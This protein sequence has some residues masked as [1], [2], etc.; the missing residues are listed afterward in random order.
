ML[1]SPD[2]MRD[3]SNMSDDPFSDILKL[4]NAELVV[5][6]GLTAGGPWAIRFPAPDHIKFLALAIVKGSCWLCIDG[7]EPV[8]G[9]AGEVVLLSAQ[10]SFVLA[11]DLAAIPVD[12]TSLYAGNVSKIAKLGDR[13]DCILIGGHVQL[14]A[15]SGGLLADVLPPL[16]HVRAGSSQATVLQWL[17]DQLVRERGVELPGPVSRWRRSPSSCSSRFCVRIS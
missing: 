17:L 6:G 5:S 15:A 14:D 2:Y 4:A 10:R 3:R 16:I 9:E 13:D 12:G 1:V 7:E 8:R 11:G